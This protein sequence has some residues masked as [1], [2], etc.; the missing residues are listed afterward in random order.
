MI[1]RRESERENMKGREMKRR[2]DK[3]KGR[4]R[5]REGRRVMRGRRGR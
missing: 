5:W 2:Q 3:R 4:G 1:G